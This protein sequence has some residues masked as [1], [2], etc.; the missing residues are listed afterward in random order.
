M[1]C[2]LC[3]AKCPPSLR[4]YVTECAHFKTDRKVIEKNAQLKPTWW[5]T[6]PRV[7]S[8]S[9]WI[10][11]DAH[12]CPYRRSEMQVAVCQ[13]ALNVMRDSEVKSN[14]YK[15]AAQRELTVPTAPI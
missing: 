15:G 10:C 2:D 1:E 3:G 4:H 6:L 14:R 13:M 7:T 12:A 8:K 5:A 11:V 9:G